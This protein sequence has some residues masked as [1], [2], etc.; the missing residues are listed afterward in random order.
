MIS[1]SL[2]QLDGLLWLLLLLA[3]FLILQQ[4]LHR[5]I[6]SIFLLLTKR[7][8]ISLVI[9]SLL[10]F[11]GVFLH[12]GSHY[13]MA[14]LLGVR[15]GRFSLI[16]R[17]LA[18]GR[19]Q[20]GYVETAQADFYRDAMIGIAPLISGGILVAYAGMVQLGMGLPWIEILSTEGNGFVEAIQ[21]IYQRSDFWIWF[22]LIFTVSSTMMPSKSDRRAWLPVSITII[23]LIAIG[24]LSGIGPW[25]AQNLAPVLNAAFR[26]ISAVFAISLIVHFILLLPLLFLRRILERLTGYR[27]A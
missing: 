12:E 25:L 26:S 2:A 13:L 22:Y 4:Q 24:V 17:P 9:F 1:F 18:N 6:Q 7:T 5:E 14:R 10:F 23:L 3:P 19:V 11:P 20:L 21:R 27:V 15:T 8:D 16:P